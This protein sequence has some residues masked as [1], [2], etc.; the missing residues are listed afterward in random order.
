MSYYSEECLPGFRFFRKDHVESNMN[1]RLASWI[2]PLLVA[3]S[4]RV[5]A[6]PPPPP[7]PGIAE[8]FGL[9]TQV[10]REGNLSPIDD[11]LANVRLWMEGQSRF[12]D[13]NQTHNLRW[14]QGLLRTALGYSIT[15]RLTIWAG[16]T[17]LPTGNS[18]RKIIGE[19]A[20]WPAI[21]Y[22]V[23]TPIGTL[24]L[25]E[26]LELRFVKGDNPG[27]RTRTMA[28]FLHSFEFEP[29]LGVVLWDEVFFNANNVANNPL[30]GLSG[31]NQNRVFA[32]LSWTFNENTRVEFGYMNLMLNKSRPNLSYS[33]Y[34]SLNTLSLS[35]FMGW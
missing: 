11:S 3:L 18:N 25:Q 23:P 30:Y 9:W 35:L 27:V 6:V 14:Y 24:M 7:A 5:L 26:M 16:Y 32:G 8:A 17:Y 19:Q 4:F 31:F 33:A 1:L 22:L 15:D 21:R 28:K 20:A 2:A 12:S 29:S 13:V 10:V 34:G